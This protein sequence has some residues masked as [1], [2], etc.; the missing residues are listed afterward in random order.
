[1]SGV[2]TIKWS[3]S[4]AVAGG[5]RNGNGAVS[6]QNMPLKIRSTVQPPKKL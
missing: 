3:V 6:G 1:L 4:G 2:Q 5:H